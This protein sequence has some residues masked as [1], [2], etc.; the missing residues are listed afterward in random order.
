MAKI[1]AVFA[2]KGIKAVSKQMDYREVGGSPLLGTSKPVIKAHG[3]SDA[4]AFKNAI[5][6][7]KEF[8]E[9]DVIGEI[10]EAVAVLGKKEA[11]SE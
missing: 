8:V 9:K 3:S 4:F 1:G 11:V 10:T 7:A 6:Q 2:M 5:R